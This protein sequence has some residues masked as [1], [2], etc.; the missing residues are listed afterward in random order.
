MGRRKTGRSLSTD[1]VENSLEFGRFTAT[2][3]SAGHGSNKKQIPENA[4]G[5]SGDEGD[6]T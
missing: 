5:R 2:L 6:F 1:F 3:I 4:F